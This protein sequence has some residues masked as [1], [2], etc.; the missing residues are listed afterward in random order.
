M[1]KIEKILQAEMTRKQFLMTL[2]GALAGMTGIAT[3]FGAF[4]KN[5][6]TP[7]SE[8]PGYGERGYGP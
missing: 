2:F 6:E 7:K 1:S 8:L 3:F 4:T 5:I